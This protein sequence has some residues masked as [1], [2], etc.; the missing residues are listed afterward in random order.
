[1]EAFLERHGHGHRQEHT[2]LL[3]RG[4]AIYRF[5]VKLAPQEARWKRMETDGNWDGSSKKFDDGSS[6]SREEQST[7]TFLDFFISKS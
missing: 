7:S 4:D 1:M 5:G 2:Q 3:L 6:W